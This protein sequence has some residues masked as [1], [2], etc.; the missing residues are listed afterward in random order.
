MSSVAKLG[1]LSRI[2]DPGSR[3][4]DLASRIPDPKTVAKG[5]GKI[6][7][8]CPG[9]KKSTG[10]RIPDPQ[11]CKKVLLVLNWKTYL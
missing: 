11:H 4:P 5:V 3:I 8:S 2:P 7:W 9:V 6:F 10:S 1:C